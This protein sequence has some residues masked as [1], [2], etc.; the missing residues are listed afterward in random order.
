MKSLTKETV[1]DR[2]N[3]ELEAQK[4]KDLYEAEQKLREKLAKRLDKAT[5]K[6]NQAQQ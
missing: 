4:Y 1:E 3:K 2:L 5:E 6:A